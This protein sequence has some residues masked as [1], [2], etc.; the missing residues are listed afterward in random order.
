MALALMFLGMIAASIYI[1]IT[2]GLLAAVISL[3]VMI[4]MFIIL[5]AVS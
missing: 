2:F 3:V 5:I 1:W 4:I